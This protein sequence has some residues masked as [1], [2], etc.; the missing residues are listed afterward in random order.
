MSAIT[1]SHK[2]LIDCVPS[3]G[4]MAKLIVAALG[5]GFFWQLASRL[6]ATA[7]TMRSGR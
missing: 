1:G 7:M 5:A 3:A 6:A 4:R 2:A